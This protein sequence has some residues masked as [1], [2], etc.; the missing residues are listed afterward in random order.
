M[1]DDLTYLHQKTVLV[2][3]AAG[4][5]GSALVE[6]LAPRVKAVRC[7]DHGEN[8]LFFMHQGLAQAGRVAP[9][10]RYRGN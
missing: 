6:A 2:T 8:D 4:T 9:D 7:F 5:I 1:A 10:Q 3:G